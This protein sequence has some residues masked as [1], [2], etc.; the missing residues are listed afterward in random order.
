MEWIVA[1]VLVAVGLFVALR[2]GQ[3]AT[4]EA[5]RWPF[6][7]KK[8]LSS[9]EQV[10]VL[11]VKKGFNFGEW[12]NRI[13]RLSL[14][15]V[16]CLKDSTVVAA[17]ELDDRSHDNRRRQDVDSRKTMALE[18]AGIKLLRWSV[19]DL[20]DKATIRAMFTT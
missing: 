5:E 9:P 15:Y 2:L 12:H 14:D 17:I 3:S 16:V 18:A 20:P 1:M 10:R 13:N 11:A 7:A 19:R 8:V 6:Y 4:S